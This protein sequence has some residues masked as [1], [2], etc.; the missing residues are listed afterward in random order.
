[1]KKKFILLCDPGP[2]W[3]ENK[4]CDE[5]KYWIEHKE[6]I[7]E[8]YEQGKVL[9]SGPI[10]HYDRIVMIYQAENESEI[11]ITLKNDPFIK[12]GILILE[13]VMEWDIKFDKYADR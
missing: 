5:Q 3:E 13:S 9:M 4:Q 8:L 10:V 12:N 7:N 2:N 1:M 6:F 11:R